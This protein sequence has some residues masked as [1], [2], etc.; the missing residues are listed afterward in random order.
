M[1]DAPDGWTRAFATAWGAGDG[2]ALAALMAPDIAM[3]GLTGGWAEGRAAVLKMLAA[4]RA[5]VMARARLVTGRARLRVLGGVVL[6]QQRFVLSGLTDA[7]GQDLPRMS[8]HLTAVLVPAGEGWQ[9]ESLT[10]APAEA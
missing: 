9:A 2:A 1:T 7:A 8:V 4:E 6:V 5:G 10:F 3:L